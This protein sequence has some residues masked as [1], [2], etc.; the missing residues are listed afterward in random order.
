MKNV[1]NAVF[2]EDQFY[3]KNLVMEFTVV[4]ESHQLPV[5][6]YDKAISSVA[7]LELFPSSL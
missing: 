7:P 3:G 6:G 1:V 5:G 2:C 4:S